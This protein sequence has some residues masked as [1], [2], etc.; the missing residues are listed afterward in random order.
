MRLFPRALLGIMGASP[1]MLPHA[2]VYLQIRAL[3][4]PAV[5]VMCVAQGACLGQQDAWTPLKIFLTA[6]L[7]NLVGDVYLILGLEWGIAGAAWATMAAQYVAA[8]FF[9]VLLWRRGRTEKGLPLGFQTMSM[10]KLQPFVAM[11]GALVS[12]TALQM[13]GYAILTYHATK[14]G[15]IASA[16]HQ[17]T[18]QMFWFFSYFPEPLSIT[19]QSLIARDARHPARM[20]RVARLLLTM[21][22]SIG[23]VL[24]GVIWGAYTFLP[25][26]FTSDEL[27]ASAIRALSPQ[28]FLSIILLCSVMV[29]DGISIGANDYSHL[30][31]TSL[32]ATGGCW[33]VLDWSYKLGFGLNM[34]WWG[35][36]LFFGL[37]FVQHAFHV[38][39][40][41]HT[42]P[43]GDMRDLVHEGGDAQGLTART[44]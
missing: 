29:L 15:L 8:A 40:H 41:W 17:V 32:V 35:M 14:L 4:S 2:L 38:A 3:A 25:R 37:R 30:P 1:E 16:A 12:R 7:F 19:A 18:L 33:I 28:A 42:H 10:S 34:V 5:M 6:G 43:L 22:S 21:G 39:T 13:T 31:R 9:L 11:S 23:L 26:F 27:V 20:K 24:A 36:V 44:V